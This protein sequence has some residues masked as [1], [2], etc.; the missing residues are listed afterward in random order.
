M[1]EEIVLTK[2]KDLES[3]IGYKFKDIRYLSKAMCATSQKYKY[4]NSKGEERDFS[5]YINQGFATVGDAILKA[6]LADYFYCEGITTRRVLT[7]TKGQ[8]ENNDTLYD[9]LNKFSL[10][11]I[12]T[13]LIEYAHNE[14]FFY[15]DSPNNCRVPN[16]KDHSQYIEALV[17]AVYY[18][19]NS[20][21][22]TYKWIINWLKP[23]LELFKRNIIY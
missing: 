10:D 7:N 3:K 22:G 18:D 1:E 15:N 8:I 16:S 12:G 14:S 6:A 2:M 17:A 5:E 4:I 13:K 11:D 20:F 19:S 21:E 9:L 23:R